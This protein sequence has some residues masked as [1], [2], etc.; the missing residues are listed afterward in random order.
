M[1]QDEPRN[2]PL[3]GDDVCRAAMRAS[4]DLTCLRISAEDFLAAVK[5]DACTLK[6]SARYSLA[7]SSL[8]AAL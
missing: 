3:G 8:A 4:T 2:H 7:T 5:Y 6:A 1:L